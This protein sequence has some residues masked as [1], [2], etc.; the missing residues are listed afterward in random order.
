VTTIRAAAFPKL[1]LC[2]HVLG[3]RPD[4]FHELEALT[5]SVGQPH[6]DLEVSLR[7]DPGV[8]LTVVD[9]TAPPSSSETG[10]LPIPE[11]PDNLAVHA[12][13]LLLG[14]VPEGD[15][16]GASLWLR[17]RIPAGAGLGGGSADAA[18]VLVA[19]RELLRA[20]HEIDV[21]DGEL[22]Q[23]AATLGSDVP[24]CVAGGGAAWMRGRGE[25]LEPVALPETLPVIVAVP[26]FR[27]ATPDVYRAFDE[28][29]GERSGRVVAA[30]D[31][32]VPLVAELRNDLEPAAET[33]EPALRDFRLE[34]ESAAGVPAL[35]AGSGSAYALV[36][37]RAP[38]VVA[39]TERLRSELDAA[40]FAAAT[41]RKGVRTDGAR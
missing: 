33:V 10:R 36:P 41:V 25:V 13:A 18:A 37:K 4:G 22:L 3:T 40:V 9:D 8:E 38:D 29:G 30:P 27:L 7:S 31:P 28:L 14:H 32:V 20:E 1:T 39:L 16:L 35:L 6:D 26:P 17:K 5:V 15:G 19:L 23:L 21:D 34:L 12:A 2:L 24:F 11:G